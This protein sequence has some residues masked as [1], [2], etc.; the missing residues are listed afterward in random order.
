MINHITMLV[1]VNIAT[2]DTERE[3]EFGRI[4]MVLKIGYVK[5]IVKI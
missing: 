2:G 1:I 3:Q 4:L 5:K